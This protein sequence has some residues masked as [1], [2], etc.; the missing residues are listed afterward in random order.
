[1]K[2]REVKIELK[3]LPWYK[4]TLTCHTGTMILILILKHCFYIFRY[5]FQT[6]FMLGSGS[7]TLIKLKGVN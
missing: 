6:Y 7:E 5:N 1:M 3:L 2:G 4:A